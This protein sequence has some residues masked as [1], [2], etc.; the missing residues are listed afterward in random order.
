MSHQSRETDERHARGDTR[1]TD[2][3]EILMALI[4]ARYGDRLTPEQVDG[5]RLGVQG[6]VEAV[7]ALRAVRLANA[8]EPHPSFSPVRAGE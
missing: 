4:K 1:V 5:V 2:E 3:I 7:T 8:D 6:V